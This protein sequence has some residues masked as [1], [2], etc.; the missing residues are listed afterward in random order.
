MQRCRCSG[1]Q[2]SDCRRFCRRPLVL[3]RAR[4][5]NHGC[6]RHEIAELLVLRQ[7]RLVIPQPRDRVPRRLHVLVRNNDELRLAL[8]LE[9]AQPFALLVEEIGGDVDRYLH[10]YARCP[11]LAQFLTDESQHRQRQ[12]LD[13]ADVADAHAPRAYDVAGLAQRRP[14]TLP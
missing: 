7:L 8:V 5:R 13:T 3:R 1:Q 9:C 4:L 6:R 10:D 14:Q 2:R 11:V 12:R